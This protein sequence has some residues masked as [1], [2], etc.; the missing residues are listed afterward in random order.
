MTLHSILAIDP[1]VTTGYCQAKLDNGILL[2]APRETKLTLLKMETMLLDAIN[3]YP[4]SLHIIYEDFQYR[5]V[6][7]TGLNLYP[8]KLI[9]VIELV[10]EKYPSVGFYKQSASTGKGYWSDEALREIGVY[11]RGTPHGRDAQRHL[12]HWLAFKEGSQ[13]VDIE[14]LTMKLA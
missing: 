10:Q 5:N 12:L 3:R 11:Q 9:G 8:V 4:Q 13:Y 2:M 1:G 6:A 14:Q 7:R